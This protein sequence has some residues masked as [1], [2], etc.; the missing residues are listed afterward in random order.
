ML[1]TRYVFGVALLLPLLGTAIPAE[2]AKDA[3]AARQA[4][5]EQAQAAA[6]A[7]GVSAPTGVKNTAGVSAYHACVKKAG[8]KP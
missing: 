5:F 1:K 6:N 7:A 3:T 4:C 8:I 2:A